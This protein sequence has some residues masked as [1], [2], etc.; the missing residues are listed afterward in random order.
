[1]GQV[2]G[3]NLAMR[4]GETL[5]LAEGVH[6]GDAS[7]V[8]PSSFRLL[9]QLL[10]RIEDPDTGRILPEGLQAEVP[11]DRLAQAKKC[12]EVL[13][14]EV[15]DQFPFLPGMTPLSDDPDE[16]VLNRTWPPAPSLP[17]I[18]GIPSL[19]SPGHGLRPPPRG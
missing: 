17:G 3:L 5:V 19:V 2:C 15:Y 18:D 16:L 12:A 10:S 4:N 13:G 6:S 8:V 14:T 7:G 9:R 11:A 1:M